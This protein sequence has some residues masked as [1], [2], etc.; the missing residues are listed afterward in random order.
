MKIGKLDFKTWSYD[1]RELNNPFVI[2]WKL[3]VWG[4]LMVS[5]IVFSALNALFHLDL[6]YFKETFNNN[7]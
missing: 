4:P 3:T 1:S 6:E 2:I 7:S 5:L